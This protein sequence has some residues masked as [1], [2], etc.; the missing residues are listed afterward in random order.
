MVEVRVLAR[1]IRAPRIVGAFAVG[2]I[3]GRRLQGSWAA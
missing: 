1:E 3:V 2:R